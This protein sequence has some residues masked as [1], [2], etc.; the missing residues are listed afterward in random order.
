MPGSRREVPVTV[1]SRHRPDMEMGRNMHAADLRWTAVVLL[2][3]VA[4]LAVFN[5]QG[6]LD[7]AMKLPV[8]WPGDSIL[9]AAGWWHD[10]MERTGATGLRRV[11]RE[12]FRWYQHL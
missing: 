9:A 12:A 5:S 11:I 3:A 10:L 4:F 1:H 2:V 7:W 6:L 8:G